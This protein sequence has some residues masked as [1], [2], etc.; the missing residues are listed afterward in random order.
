MRASLC[1]RSGHRLREPTVSSAMTD[2]MTG[3]FGPGVPEGTP[4]AL[5]F[6]G[7]TTPRGAPFDRL[8][9]LFSFQRPRARGHLIAV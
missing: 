2:R 9:T 6:T 8:L 3:L 4:G 5:A 7:H 1:Q